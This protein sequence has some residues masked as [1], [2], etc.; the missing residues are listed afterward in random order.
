MVR[1]QESMC[2]AVELA[3]ISYDDGLPQ[4]CYQTMSWTNVDLLK[5]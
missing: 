1:L 3:N 4:V 5:L 2:W